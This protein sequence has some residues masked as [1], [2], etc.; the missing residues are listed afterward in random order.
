MFLKTNDTRAINLHT[1]AEFRVREDDLSV[2][3]EW[4]VVGYSEF[5]SEGVCFGKYPTKEQAVDKLDRLLAAIS[6]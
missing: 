1:I 3:G 5:Y 4:E 6:N 2:E